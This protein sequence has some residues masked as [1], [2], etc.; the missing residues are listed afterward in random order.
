MTML[1]HLRDQAAHVALGA[2]YAAPFA[3]MGGAWWVCLAAALCYGAVRESEQ[4]RKRDDP[5]WADT[6]VDLA[7]TTAG[8]AVVGVLV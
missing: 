7:F 8:G 1:G 6:A 4:W 5:K 2:L 3:L